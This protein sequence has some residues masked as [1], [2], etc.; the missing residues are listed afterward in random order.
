MNLPNKLTILR[1]ILVPV[2]VALL[3]LT[4]SG[5]MQLLAAAV[6]AAASLTDWL[7]GYLARKNGQ[8]TDFGKLMD[9]M[10]DKLLVMS[11]LVGLVA[12]GRASWLCTMILLAR[13]FFISAVRLVAASRGIVIA[14]GMVGKAKTVTQMIAILLLLAAPS[15]PAL[16]LPGQIAL[17]ISAVLSAWSMIEYT[18]Q[19]KEVFRT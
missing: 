10:A 1:M 16:E 5:A 17:W 9:P 3:M 4:E 14:A 2:F 15:L 12:L 13:E 19:N 11:A 18:V 8:V 7:D 6:F